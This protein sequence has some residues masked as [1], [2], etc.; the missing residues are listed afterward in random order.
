LEKTR[1][2][3]PISSAAGDGRG[4]HRMEQ[5]TDGIF[6]QAPIEWLS[7]PEQLDQLVRITRPFD[8]VAATAMALGLVVLLAWGLLG[9]IPTRV[10]GEGILLASGG[11]VVDA[12]SAVAGRLASLDV[13]VGD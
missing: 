7:S 9:K 2:L 4:R 10:E 6:R 12:V 1:L 5:R 13:A 3:P 11:R 8:W